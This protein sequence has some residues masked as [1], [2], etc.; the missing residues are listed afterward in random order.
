MKTKGTAL[1]GPLSMVTA[2]SEGAGSYW[3]CLHRIDGCGEVFE[4]YVKIMGAALS[5][6]SSPWP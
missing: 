3:Q 5:V 1:G 6:V 4:T 2:S